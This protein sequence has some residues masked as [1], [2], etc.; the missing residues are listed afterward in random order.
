MGQAL[1]K[2][3]S[4]TLTWHLKSSIIGAYISHSQM[5]PRISITQSALKQILGA[6]IVNRLNQN[7]CRCDPRVFI[8]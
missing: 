1:R 3:C 5:W 8:F 2:N 4:F 7:L 6:M